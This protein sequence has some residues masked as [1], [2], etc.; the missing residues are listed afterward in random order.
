[1]TNQPSTQWDDPLARITPVEPRPLDV[2]CTHCDVV[3]SL[4]PWPSSDDDPGC[5]I[6]R[7]K[8][9]LLDRYAHLL[10]DR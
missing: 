4:H 9:D 3:M 5:D 2:F 8:A 1:M 6:A 10:G 7:D